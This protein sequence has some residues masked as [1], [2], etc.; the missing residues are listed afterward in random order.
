MLL[1]KKLGPIKDTKFMADN[2]D[3][4]SFL[5]MENF[6]TFY[7]WV[8]RTLN[9]QQN[10]IAFTNFQLA[11]KHEKFRRIRYLKQSA[12]LQILLLPKTYSI[13]VLAS[14]G[15]RRQ[16]SIQTENVSSRVRHL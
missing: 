16:S 12:P 15:H 6:L 4:I 9:L 7:D 8:I 13:F 14:L 3:F 5:N 1:W 2:S 10:I 11:F